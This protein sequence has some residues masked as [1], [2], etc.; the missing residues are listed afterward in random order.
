MRSPLTW[1]RRWLARHLTTPLDTMYER[2]DDHLLDDPR[3]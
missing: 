2:I 1:F 3:R